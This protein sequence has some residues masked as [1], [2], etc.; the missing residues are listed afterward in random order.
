MIDSHDTLAQAPR[1]PAPWE[2]QGNAW[3]VALRLPAQSPVRDAWLPAEMAGQGRGFISWL[4]Y[5]DYVHSPCGPYRELLFVPGAYRCEDG[6]RHPTISR[7]VVSTWDSVVNGRANWGIPKDRADFEV[8]YSVGGRREDR[9]RVVAEGGQPICSLRL[10]TSAMAPRLPFPGRLVPERW[11]TL[12][13]SYQGRTYYYAP[14]ASGR[15]RPGR[16]LEASFNPRT[17]P[18]LNAAAVIAAFR[19]DTFRMSFPVARVVPPGTTPVA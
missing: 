2:L 7:I 14:A 9:V 17:F 13:Q 1:Y 15:L 11:R 8:E 6:R 19:V 10:S 12:A 18:D 3:M 5:V 4:M 16:L